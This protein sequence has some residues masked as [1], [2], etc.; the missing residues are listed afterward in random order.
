MA[1]SDRRIKENIVDTPDNLA[2]Q[3]VRNIPC[4]Y[5]EYRDKLGRGSDKTIGFIAQEVNSVLPM[6]VSIQTGI[7]PSVYKVISCEWTGNVMYSQELGTVSG[8]KYKFYVSNT[9]NDEVEKIVNGNDDNTFTFEQQWTN[10]FCYGYEVEDFHVLDKNKL[11][12]L[13]FSATQELDRIQQQELT[14]VKDLEI[15]NFLLK[16]RVKDLES[17]MNDVLNRL[18]QL[19][20]N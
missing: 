17:K 7:I 18:A 3:Q 8:V 15:E 20:N 6:A 4:R 9:E 2:L 12:A 13:N 1:S 11:F 5:Y 14:K 16:E 10:V 19:E